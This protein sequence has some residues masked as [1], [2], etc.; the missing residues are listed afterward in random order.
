MSDKIQLIKQE[1]ERLKHTSNAYDRSRFMLLL[2]I[3]K[4]I[5]SLPEEPKDEANC[6]TKSEDLEEE[7]EKIWTNCATT[8]VPSVSGESS[9]LEENGH[10]ELNL[11]KSDFKDIV[12]HFAKWQKQQMMKDAIESVSC[13]YSN[14]EGTF[15]HIKQGIDTKDGDK[16]KI[17]IVK[18]D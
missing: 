14:K 13:T 1:I 9:L 8:W 11:S 5:D 15:L 16:V 17:L 10:Y 6:T 7:I 4:F 3:E 2:E 12:R 18:E